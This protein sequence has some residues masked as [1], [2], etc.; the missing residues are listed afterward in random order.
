MTTLKDVAVKSEDKLAVTMMMTN[1]Q[2][3]AAVALNLGK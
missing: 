1:A 3:S 2:E